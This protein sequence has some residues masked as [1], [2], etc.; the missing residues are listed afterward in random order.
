MK[1]WHYIALILGGLTLLS[2]AGT[3]ALANMAIGATQFAFGGLSSEQKSSIKAIVREFERYGDK[4]GSKLAYIIATA[5]HESRLRPVR[6]CFANSDIEAR[7]CV[8]SLAYGNQINGQVYYGRGFVQ[9]TWY[10]NYLKMGNWLGIDLVN[11]P[12]LA[13][14]TSIA[15]KILVY[16]MYNGSF[17][18]KKLSDY[19][20]PSLPFNDFYNARRIV[21][22]LDRAQLINDYAISLTQY[23]NVA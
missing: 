9:L 16:G 19:I 2:F 18:G 7:Q 13:L 15:A 10:D 5:W 23:N 14:N 4:D 1:P 11:N 22:G 20:D 21:N 8:A 12:D 17:T 6:E 3:S